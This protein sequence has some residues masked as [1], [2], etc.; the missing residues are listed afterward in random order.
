LEAPSPFSL[1]RCFSQSILHSTHDS[2]SLLPVSTAQE[3][4]PNE[5]FSLCPQCLVRSLDFFPRLKGKCWPFDFPD[6]LHDDSRIQSPHVL[7]ERDV[8]GLVTAKIDQ[9][10]DTTGISKD[11]VDASIREPNVCRW[12]SDSK[13][14]NDV[15]FRFLTIKR[16]KVI[17][18]GNALT[19]LTEIRVIDALAKFGL[20]HQDDLNELLSLCF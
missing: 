14:V 13:A 3:G 11:G 16:L 6:A 18:H 12:A 8:Q 7:G 17:P 5:R 10:R 9:P 19:Q 1:L 15:L 20:T 4:Q 2:D